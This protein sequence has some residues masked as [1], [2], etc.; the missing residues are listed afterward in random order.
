M[1][2][3]N[4]TAKFLKDDPGKK[5]GSLSDGKAIILDIKEGRNIHIEMPTY[6]IPAEMCIRDR[7]YTACHLRRPDSGT[8]FHSGI[9]YLG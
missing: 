9:Q 2:I 5:D 3:T 4:E 8:G 1:S 6:G 7:F